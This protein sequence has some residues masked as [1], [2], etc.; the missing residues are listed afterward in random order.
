MCD[1][2]RTQEQIV[3]DLAKETKIE[4]NKI[5]KAVSGILAELEQVGLIQKI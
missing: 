1:G 3:D 4:R 5:D 2:N